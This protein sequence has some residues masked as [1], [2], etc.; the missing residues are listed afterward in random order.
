MTPGCWR[1]N[2]RRL[3]EA[4]AYLGVG[5]TDVKG[6]PW[7]VVDVYDDDDPLMLVPVDEERVF[8]ITEL[9]RA[10]EFIK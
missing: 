5:V 9:A 7:I 4:L 10:L 2:E 8:S 6:D 3:L 1:D